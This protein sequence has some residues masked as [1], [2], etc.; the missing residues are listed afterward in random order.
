MGKFPYVQSLGMFSWILTDLFADW[1][2]QAEHMEF[3]K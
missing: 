1:R 2:L 3:R